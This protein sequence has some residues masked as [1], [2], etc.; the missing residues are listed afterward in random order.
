MT[1]TQHPK[2]MNSGNPHS[3]EYVTLREFIEVQLQAQREYFDVKTDAQ[4]E[5]LLSLQA[6]RDKALSVAFGNQSAKFEKANELRE[7]VEDILKTALTKNEFIGFKDALDKTLKEMSASTKDAYTKSEHYAFKE[8]LDRE[9]DELKKAKNITEGKA[10][11][12]SVVWAYVIAVTGIILGILE[13][14]IK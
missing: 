11:Q 10:S 13:K 14:F 8:V 9:L 1:V 2:R 7:V 6:E 12:S 4:K 5:F 3:A